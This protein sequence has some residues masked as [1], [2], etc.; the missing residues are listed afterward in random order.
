M[1]KPKAVLFDFDGTLVDSLDLLVKIF[2]QCFQA[3][4]STKKI[5]PAK[6]RSLIGFP[7]PVIFEKLTGSNNPDQIKEFTQRFQTLEKKRHTP[8]DLPLFSGVPKILANL[9]HLKLGIVSTKP[10]A[11]IEPYLQAL[12]LRQFF[13]SIIGGEDSQNPKP[14]PEPLLLACQQLAVAT[15]A[16]IFIGDSS[17]DLLAAQAAGIPF[18]GVLTGVATSTDFQRHNLKNIH[19][20]VSAIRNLTN[21]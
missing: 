8:K 2:S 1:L 14:H 19:P 15:S 7:L 18:H 20:S 16:T 3:Q 10:R 21:I 6:I 13:A 9:K 4:G 5:T 11:L 17:L 12:E